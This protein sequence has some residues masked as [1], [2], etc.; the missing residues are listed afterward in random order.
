MEMLCVR[1]TAMMFWLYVLMI[2]M[3]IIASCHAVFQGRRDAYCPHEKR[4]NTSNSRG[5]VKSHLFCL[6][7]FMAGQISC[8]V[9]CT[10]VRERLFSH[11]LRGDTNLRPSPSAGKSL[12]YRQ[13]YTSFSAEYRPYLAETLGGTLRGTHCTVFWLRT[14]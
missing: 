13:R 2:V 10:S 11:L 9:L 8:R 6:N 7:C 5:T 3:I 12:R 4:G 14:E 1:D